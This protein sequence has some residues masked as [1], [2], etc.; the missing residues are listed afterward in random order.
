MA[1]I[2]QVLEELY[3]LHVACGGAWTYAR[4]LAVPRVRASGAE[5]EGASWR[6]GFGQR[7]QRERPIPRAAA[8]GV[9]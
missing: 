9:P 5:R 6:D 2:G 4:P 3:W 1:R 7:C 8:G